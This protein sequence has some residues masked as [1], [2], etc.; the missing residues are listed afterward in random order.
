[1]LE[2]RP[3]R[4]DWPL[5]ESDPTAASSV[6]KCVKVDHEVGRLRC[7][8]GGERGEATI[9]D[10]MTASRSIASFAATA[11]ASAQPA[12]S[13][14]N[15]SSSGAPLAF[16]TTRS[17]CPL[18]ATGCQIEYH[19]RNGRVERVTSADET[20]NS[21]NLCINGRFGY[22]YINSLT[23]SQIRWSMARSLTGMAP[24]RRLSTDSRLSSQ[25]TAPVP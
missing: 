15:R 12:R 2:R 7:H 1:V 13:S 11:S 18:C 10:T 23:V 20:Y 5:I 16:T 17:I 4:Y 21:G 25:T 3:I 14:A 19:T 24:W 22:S 8:C 6:K 9:I